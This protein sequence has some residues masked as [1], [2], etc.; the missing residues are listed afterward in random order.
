MQKLAF[1]FSSLFICMLLCSNTLSAQCNIAGE[2]CF[3]RTDYAGQE[4]SPFDTRDDQFQFLFKVTGATG[5]GY[6][7]YVGDRLY[8]E[9]APAQSYWFRFPIGS[10]APITLKL[11]Q[12]GGCSKTVSVTPPSKNRS[13]VPCNVSAYITGI[14]C[15][16]LSTRDYPG[17]DKFTFDVQAYDGSMF[18]DQNYE[19]YVTSY[20]QGFYNFYYGG[21]SQNASWKNWS[22]GWANVATAAFGSK[23]NVGKHYIRNFGGGSKLA[24][25]VARKDDPSC[26]R[27]Y[28]LEVPQPCSLNPARKAGA[29]EKIEA[30]TSQELN[31]P[32]THFTQLLTVANVKNT[33][34][35]YPNPAREQV[36]IETA[37]WE[38]ETVARIFNMEGKMM[39]QL[40]L[41]GNARNEVNISDLTK[42]MYF[43]HLN[44]G[45]TTTS[46]KFTVK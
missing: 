22:G 1:F 7:V 19:V 24:V 40:M 30:S 5:A 4:P 35:I 11:V 38:G 36:T 37:G 18:G 44:N 26:Y 27:L 3:I 15:D 28:T 45:T 34:S 33:L 16:P 29:Q 42:G 6:Q 23:V 20:T 13:I 10:G 14:A 12:L 9:S 41:N 21:G 25:V 43:L 8:I 39:R 2:V 17:D 31:A 46:E 32:N